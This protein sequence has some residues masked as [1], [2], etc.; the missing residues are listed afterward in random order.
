MF[1]FFTCKEKMCQSKFSF[2]KGRDTGQYKETERKR[3]REGDYYATDHCTDMVL[4]LLIYNLL[5]F[6]CLKMYIIYT[7]HF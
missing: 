1:T 2:G 5:A 3:K 7:G 4:K 6:K